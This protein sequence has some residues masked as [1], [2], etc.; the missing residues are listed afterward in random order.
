MALHIKDAP[1]I[2]IGNLHH[3]NDYVATKLTFGKHKG[4]WLS[5]VPTDY[6]KWAVLNLD[7]YQ[8]TMFAVELQ[9]RDK[10]FRK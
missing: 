6:V 9:R 8:A 3:Y 4:K 10:S 2:K 5:E 1:T 7:S